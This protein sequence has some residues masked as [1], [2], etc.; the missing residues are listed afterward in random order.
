MIMATES[1]KMKWDEH[2]F[3]VLRIGSLFASLALDSV[4]AIIFDPPFNLLL[5]NGP[6]LMWSLT[7]D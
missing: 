4:A 2:V 3:P 6:F 1:G 5:F 7:I